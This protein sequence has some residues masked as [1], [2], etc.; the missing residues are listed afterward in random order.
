MRIVIGVALAWLLCGAAHGESSLV[1]PPSEAP[2]RP[3]DWWKAQTDRTLARIDTDRRD[4]FAA[5]VT[6]LTDGQVSSGIYQYGSRF[7]YWGPGKAGKRKLMAR[8]GSLDADPVVVFDATNFNTDM[9]HY[10]NGWSP[11]PRG[12][13][14][15]YKEPD[16]NGKLFLRVCSVADQRLLPERIPDVDWCLVAWDAHEVGFSY[17]RKYDSGTGRRTMK[18]LY[19]HLGTHHDRDVVELD[20]PALWPMV[21][22]TLDGKYQWRRVVLYDESILL[23]RRRFGDFRFVARAPRLWPQSISIDGRLYVHF[24]GVTPCPGLV[25]LHLEQLEPPFEPWTTILPGEQGREYDSFDHVSRDLALVLEDWEGTRRPRIYDPTNNWTPVQE[26][27]VPLSSVIRAISSDQD[28]DVL[29]IMISSPTNPE[30]NYL[31]DL[32]TRALT[33]CLTPNAL[34]PVVESYEV[35]LGDAPATLQI[36][37]A[38]GVEPSRAT[39]IRVDYAY[40]EPQNMAI[41][42]AMGAWMENGGRYVRLWLPDPPSPDAEQRHAALIAAAIRQLAAEGDRLAVWADGPTFGAASQAITDVGN[43]IALIAEDPGAC[44]S[45]P[46]IPTLVVETPQAGDD[47]PLPMSIRLLNGQAAT[48]HTYGVWAPVKTRE[49]RIQ[50]LA[51]VLAFAEA[52][53]AR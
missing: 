3:S 23:V 45:A 51:T 10:H 7:F 4:A 43:V 9:E 48:A 49:D 50:L 36:A 52:E 42:P 13:Y 41:E 12:T 22:N 35:D 25:E 21:T 20:Q 11:S 8:I 31:Y 19:H 1:G 37:V 5:R 18:G 38:P 27:P 26:I 24:N 53:L 47:L 16:E 39:L 28:S 30:Q 46:P 29:T 17:A 40:G 34:A 2:T 33:H 14:V 6:H 44:K 32:A 15:A